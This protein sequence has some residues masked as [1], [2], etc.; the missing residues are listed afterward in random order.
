MDSL[1]LT[2]VLCKYLPK[3]LHLALLFHVRETGRYPEEDVNRAIESTL[4]KTN[5][6]DSLIDIKKEQG[7]STEALEALEEQKEEVLK[8]LAE[9]EESCKL[10]H[11]LSSDDNQLEKE[12]HS[13]ETLR[14]Q[15]DI[16]EKELNNLFN[17]LMFQFSCG[18]YDSTPMVLSK[19]FIP[20]TQNESRKMEAYWG[21]LTSE[22]LMGEGYIDNALGTLK[23]LISLEKNLE[24]VQ[25]VQ[26]R[27]KTLDLSSHEDTKDDSSGPKSQ[28]SAGYRKTEIDR[29]YER[30]TLLH[31]SLFL[32]F[33][34]GEFDQMLG[35][36]GL[37]RDERYAPTIS[38]VCPHLY[39][40]VVMAAFLNTSASD[41]RSQR[42]ELQEIATLLDDNSFAYKDSL[43]EFLRLLVL[44]NDFEAA[45]VALEES[46]ELISN[47]F[48]M[49]Y[50]LDVFNEAARVVILR[51]HCLLFQRIKISDLSKFML[52]DNEDECLAFV[53]S[54]FLEDE[55]EIDAR[56][57]D[58]PFAGER[59]I[60]VRSE[61]QTPYQQLLYEKAVALPGK[62]RDLYFELV[63][64]NKKANTK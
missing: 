4:C 42:T 35:R 45:K 54:K 55:R 21:V 58:D 27:S 52:F 64:R 37:F 16:G 49:S 50:Y 56:I 20:F 2:P 30:A 5:L 59:Y 14:K 11:I 24:K 3:H 9:E 7:A 61:Q 28:H 62:S 25:N 10:L 33:N 23:E 18:K 6:V 53:T 17:V 32:F 29:M 46:Q 22:I 39:R 43:T 51:R 19:Y 40:Y 15:Y 44:E 57:H 48:F 63:K 31:L 34:K 47:D 41:T 60:H 26:D 12:R 1:D 8:K 13:V 38:T 36:D